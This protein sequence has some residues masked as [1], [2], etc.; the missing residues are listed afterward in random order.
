MSLLQLLPYYQYYVVPKLTK[1]DA[2]LR[3]SPTFWVA[4]SNDYKHWVPCPLASVCPHYLQS[5]E[6][7]SVHPISL[8]KA[9]SSSPCSIIRLSSKTCATSELHQRSNIHWTCSPPIRSSPTPFQTHRP[10][11]TVGSREGD[12][13]QLTLW[14]TGWDEGNVHPGKQSRF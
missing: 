1:T 9:S 8:L 3:N 7:I 13:D 6:I 12:R 11:R 2:T 14:V 5:F 10:G 4:H